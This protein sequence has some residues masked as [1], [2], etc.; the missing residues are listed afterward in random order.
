MTAIST[1]GGATIEQ[2]RACVGIKQGTHIPG[3]TGYTPLRKYR[4]GKTYGKDTYEIN[5]LLKM[6]K[7][8][9]PEILFEDE[10]DT[11]YVDEYC[12][13]R[14]R[15]K[16]EE[17]MR[18]WED[19]Q[20]NQQNWTVEGGE[21][22]VTTGKPR[23]L[24]IPEATGDNKYFKEMVPG[25]TGYVP[26]SPYKFGNRYRVICDLSIDDFM[27]ANEKNAHEEASLRNTVNRQPVLKSIAPDSEVRES[28]LQFR[29]RNPNRQNV[30]IEEKRTGDEAPIPGYVGYVPKVKPTEI[31]LGARYHTVSKNGFSVF[32]N[33]ME[34]T[35]AN[36]NAPISLDQRP[37]P[38][39]Y[40]VNFRLDSPG[41]RSIYAP[42]GM[43]PNYTGYLPQRQAIKEQV[44]KFGHTYGNTSRSLAVCEQNPSSLIAT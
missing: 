38:Q 18:K 19:S 11:E 21:L 26:T 36:R 10:Y 37:T 2:R 33:E 24:L 8:K 25:Y 6:S 41:T 7:T 15:R 20:C 14:L 12:Y 16:W 32:Y 43:V 34:R 23:E 30:L 27:H 40:N 17:S 9:D 22:E 44:F 31:G 35:Q 29:E 1:G 5:T 28:C 13:G 3:Y 39:K 42:E 4:I